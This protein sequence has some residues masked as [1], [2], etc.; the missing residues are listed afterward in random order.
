M[1]GMAVAAS[2]PS[3][4]I[5]LVKE[6]MS[7]GMAIADVLRTA[8]PTPLINALVEDLKARNTKP[9]MP[10]GMTTRAEADAAA[11][12]A[13]KNVNEI[14]GRKCAP[15][16]ATEYKKWLLALGQRVAEASNEGGFFGI[17]GVRVSDAEKA[18]LGRIAAALKVS[19]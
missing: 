7:I 13:H 3:G 12:T 16:E 11:M 19:V 14:V 8:S 6:M 5:G 9:E 1:V 15:A 2:S 17:G 10:A 18:A 4:P